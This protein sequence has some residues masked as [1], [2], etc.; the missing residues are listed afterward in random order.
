MGE[1]YLDE[2]TERISCAYHN[3]FLIAIKKNLNLRDIVEF[4]ATEIEEH[5]DRIEGFVPNGMDGLMFFLA[6]AQIM[7]CSLFDIL[8]LSEKEKERILTRIIDKIDVSAIDEYE[9]TEENTYFVYDYI[10]DVSDGKRIDYELTFR[11]D[12]DCCRITG[13]I[14]G[15]NRFGFSTD[16][17]YDILELWKGTEGEICRFIVETVEE[18]IENE[19]EKKEEHVDDDSEENEETPIDYKD[20]F[21]HSYRKDCNHDY[22]KVMATV[23]VY[24]GYKVKTV[25][26]EA[27]YCAECGIYYI[28]EY[29]YQNQ[30][31]PV[32]HL[33]CQVLSMEEYSDYKKQVSNG[34]ELKPQSILAMIGY[35][36]NKRFNLSDHERQTILRY[37]LEAGVITKRRTINYLQWFIKTNG[38]RKGMEDSVS[39]WKKD[40][41]W[42]LNFDKK[43]D[44]IYGVKRI[45]KNSDDD[46]MSIPDEIE[47]YLPFK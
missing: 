8:Y 9:C 12:D 46:F 16:Y 27:E 39:K 18:L 15:D 35:T 23:P 11:Y 36:T 34:M 42:V 5:I 25:S 37:A 6:V 17:M 29:T 43:G 33:L 26:F 40:L 22:I 7:D 14:Y 44:I 19:D 20:F 13:R 4:A 10:F 28:S 1:L 31:L 47:N 3:M 30:I 38:A 32:G 24:S 2:I 41:Q 45:I 21:I